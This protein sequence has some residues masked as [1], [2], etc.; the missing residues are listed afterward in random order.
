M[1]LVALE[2]AIINSV[3]FGV[4]ERTTLAGFGRAV[5]DLATYA[6]AGIGFSVGPGSLTYMERRP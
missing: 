4:F 5:T 6:D 3:C 2:R 1:T